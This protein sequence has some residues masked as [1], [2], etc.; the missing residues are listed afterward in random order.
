M[1]SILILGAVMMCDGFGV[2]VPQWVSPAATFVVVVFFF[3]RS[4][5]E[6]RK[7]KPA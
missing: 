5:R 2:E 3:L 1:Y 6:M 4:V 7:A